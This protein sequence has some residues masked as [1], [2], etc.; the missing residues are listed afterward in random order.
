MSSPLP[1]QN[2]KSSLYV[3]STHFKLKVFHL[4]DSERDSRLKH[5]TSAVIIGKVAG[6]TQRC[7]ECR[8][9]RKKR[10]KM[11]S[12]KSCYPRS[13][14]WTRWVTIRLCSDACEWSWDCCRVID[15][16]LNFL[17]DCCS[18]TECSS[19]GR[20]IDCRALYYIRYCRK[21]IGRWFDSGHSEMNMAN[22]TIKIRATLRLCC[23]VIALA[24]I[25][26]RKAIRINIYLHW[27]WVAPFPREIVRAV[28]TFPPLISN[29]SSSIRKI[30]GM[31]VDYDTWRV[32]SYWES[33]RYDAKTPEHR[34]RIK[35]NVMSG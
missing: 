17:C 9:A 29:H 32:P 11:L 2:C 30:V 16:I 19:V 1:E 31:T 6:I 14:S 3:S 5:V 13:E 10:K 35:Q 22:A 4:Q 15:T 21:S 23:V 18:S 28:Y 27:R 24:C 26:S 12:C 8:D 25:E 7:P 34:D 33:S 20:A